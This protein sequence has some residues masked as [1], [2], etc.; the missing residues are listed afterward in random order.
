MTQATNLTN[1]LLIA[2]PQLTDPDFFQSVTYICEHSEAGALGITINR[3]LNRTL[4]QMLPEIDIEAS[5]PA[6]S[7]Q[8]VYMGGPVHPNRGFV[9]HT[10]S[11][12][13]DST[14]QI[15]QQISLTTSPDILEAIGKGC[16]P[17][18]I[19]VALGYASWSEGQLEQEMMDNS[20]LNTEA[21]Y[22][23]IF[24]TDYQLRWPMAAKKLGIDLNQLSNVTGHA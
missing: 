12:V 4:Q 22:D 15:N 16:G 13:W 19:L 10:P 6:L 5:D 23:I 17:S 11:T 24:K 2:M 21:D 8:Y 1:H 20:W 3:P 7:Q 18:Q 14:L 9:L